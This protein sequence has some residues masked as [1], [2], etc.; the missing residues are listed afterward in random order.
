MTNPGHGHPEENE[1]HS[2][3][4]NIVSKAYI[5]GFETYQAMHKQS[6]EDPDAFWAKTAEDLIFWHKKWELPVCK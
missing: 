4:D 3:P 5:K 2:P 6:L 1:K